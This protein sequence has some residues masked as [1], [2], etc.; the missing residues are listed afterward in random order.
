MTFDNHLSQKSVIVKTNKN[1][2]SISETIE[3][4]FFNNT[5]DSVF[6]HIGSYTPLYAIRY[7]ERKNCENDWKQYFVQCQYPNCVIDIDFP[8]IIKPKQTISFKW[9]PIIFINGSIKHEKI[10]TGR[11]RIQL[12]YLNSEKIIWQTTYSNE[13]TI[14]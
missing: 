9:E 1:E 10:K 6:S 2:Y 7:L 8:V 14:K 11:Y 3:V 5:L 4:S 13:F 12:H